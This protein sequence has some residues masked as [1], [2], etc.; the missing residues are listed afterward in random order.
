VFEKDLRAW[1]AN[2]D[3]L[4]HFEIVPVGTSA[5]ALTAIAPQL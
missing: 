4:V 3:D 1:T 5:E 2:W